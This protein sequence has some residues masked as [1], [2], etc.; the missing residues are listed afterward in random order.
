MVVKTIVLAK[1]TTGEPGLI[2]CYGVLP[3]DK[4]LQAIAWS[5]GD[6]VTGVFAQVIP[7]NDTIVQIK[8]APGIECLLLLGREI[9]E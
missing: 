3:G 4:L 6:N 9:A 7:D 5:N 2:R 8:P 1:A